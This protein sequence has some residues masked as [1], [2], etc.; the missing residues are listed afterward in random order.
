MAFAYP[1]NL[2]I[3]DFDNTLV[4]SERVNAELFAEFFQTFG[5]VESDQHDHEFVDSAAFVEVIRHY[6]RRYKSVLGGHGESELIERFL[7]YKSRRLPEIGLRTATG[8]DE[9]LELPIAKAIV[10]G[11]YSREIVAGAKAAGLAIGSFALVLGSD[12]YF[13]WKPNPAGLLLAASRLDRVPRV[14]AVLEDSISGLTAARDAGMQPVFIGEFSTVGRDEA[15]KLTTWTF[16]TIGE[17]AR[18]LKQ[19]A[20]DGS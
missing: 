15:T 7:Q 11:S 19:L 1:F 14:S 10:S 13:P 2:V 3:C 20:A 9:L 8:L 17:F 5:G 6:Q 18:A 4:E 12:E 16:S